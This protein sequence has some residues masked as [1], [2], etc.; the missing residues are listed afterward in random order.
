MKPLIAFA[1]A[2]ALLMVSVVMPAPVLSGGCGDVDDNG[3]V[4]ATDALMV[5]HESVGADPGLDCGTVAV[6]NVVELAELDE[7]AMEKLEALLDA[8]SFEGDDDETIVLTGKN[9]QIVSGEGETDAEPN[10]LGNLIIGYNEDEFAANDRSGSHN[11]VVGREH[12]YSSYGGIVAGVANGVIAPYA[13]VCGGEFNWA[14]ATLSSV[15][16]GSG[17]LAS[18]RTSHVAG[19]RGNTASGPGSAVSGGA[20]NSAGGADATVAG[21]SGYTANVNGTVVPR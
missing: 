18:G 3:T 9:L 7:D 16:G 2:A 17:N 8:L 12:I 6:T 19:G 21:G 15:G 13:S 20:S 4:N 10:G 11:L 14:T 5:L 1:A